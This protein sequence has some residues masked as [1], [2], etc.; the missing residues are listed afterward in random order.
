[1]AVKER[2]CDIAKRLH[3]VRKRV[4]GADGQPPY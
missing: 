4:P 1:M 2:S 3:E